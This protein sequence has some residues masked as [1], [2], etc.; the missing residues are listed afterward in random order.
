MYGAAHHR[1]FPQPLNLHQWTQVHIKRT[2]VETEHT[3]LI[4]S[5]ML[6]NKVILQKHEDSIIIFFKK[7]CHIVATTTG[8]FSLFFS[9]VYKI[10]ICKPVASSSDMFFICLLPYDNISH[11]PNNNTIKD[12]CSKTNQEKFTDSGCSAIQ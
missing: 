11:L 3:I 7:T 8:K 4:V 9:F 12:Q 10:E 6:K 2:K 1:N 5:I